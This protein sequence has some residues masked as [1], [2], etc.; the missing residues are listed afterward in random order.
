MLGLG[1]V[2]VAMLLV[3]VGCLLDFAA[4]PWQRVRRSR[5]EKFARRQMLPVTVENGPLVVRYLATTRRW[6]GGFM[7]LTML[8]WLV[9]PTTARL[10]G[11]GGPISE[12]VS[13]LSLFVGWFVGA[14]I[15]EWR[16][17]STARPPGARRTA[18]LEPR[19][20]ADYVPG[21]ARLVPLAA[22]GILIGSE[23][24]GL[25]AV[26]LR[27][28][29]GVAV[30]LLWLALT[31]VAGAVLAAVGRQ[32]LVRPQRYI[33]DGL[34]TADD[35]LR[36]RSLHVLA[37]S[38]LALAGYLLGGFVH[39]MTPYSSVLSDGVTGAIGA[40]GFLAAPIFG[41]IVA[42]SAAAPIRRVR[43]NRPGTAPVSAS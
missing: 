9:W 13:L 1:W 15:A 19:R 20:L 33:D 39:V 32:V 26:V 10:F 5:V 6:R 12:N 40:I 28:G 4:T 14:V 23:L 8:S 22:W 38:A 3:I 11:S 30:A 37:G 17:S 36:S 24:A 21:R 18:A 27:R 34:V 41:F 16:V 2:V 31:A 25:G 42:T 29:G 35:A 43:R 7:L